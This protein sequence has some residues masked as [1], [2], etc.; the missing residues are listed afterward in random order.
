MLYARVEYKGVVGMGIYILL[1]V[2]LILDSAVLLDEAAQTDITRMLTKNRFYRRASHIGC[3]V[4]V[5]G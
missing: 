1:A 4:L 3:P 2:K 5:E